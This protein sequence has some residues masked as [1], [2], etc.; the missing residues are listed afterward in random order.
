[1]SCNYADGLSP[2]HDKGVLGV[3]EIFESDEKVREKCQIL[4]G[5][6]KTSRHVVVHTGAGIST[7]AG[8]PDFRGPNGVWTLQKKGEK[9]NINISFNE[10]VPTKTHMALKKLID[11][12]LV[13][14]IVSQNID[15]LHLKSGV[16]RRY[17]GELHGN[18][19]VEQC[20]VCDSQFVRS[21]ATTSVGQKNL[22]INCKRFQRFCRGKLCDTILDWEDNLPDFD[23]KLCELHSRVADLNICL[24]TT[25]QIVPSGRLPMSCK[26]YGGKVVIVNLQPTKYDKKADLRINSYVDLVL[27]ELMNS[28]D[29]EIP[30]YKIGLDPTKNAELTDNKIVVEWTISK[31]YIK[32]AQKLFDVHCKNHKK[33][34][35]VSDF[36]SIYQNKCIKTKNECKIELKDEI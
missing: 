29:L 33:R 6:I 7:S 5:W 26:K 22:N 21:E 16:H 9:P 35:L 18:M 4:A 15:G 14:Y 3:P 17:L 25:L 12:G 24:G 1:M 36:K 27:S 10:A 31:S 13:K 8:I 20:N 34:K 23:L 11:E 30:E 19:F 32:E 2:Y 28:L